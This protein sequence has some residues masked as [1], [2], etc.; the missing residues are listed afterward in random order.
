MREDVRN[1]KSIENTGSGSHGIMS[2][3]SIVC[4]ICSSGRVLCLVCTTCCF[5]RGVLMLGWLCAL[6]ASPYYNRVESCCEAFDRIITGERGVLNLPLSTP[7]IHI[8]SKLAG[9]KPGLSFLTHSDPSYSHPS[10]SS[11]MIRLCQLL[12]DEER[13]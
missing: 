13:P 10:C 3:N 1:A 9:S 8:S 5:V 7:D 11:S 12:L 2:G 6:A 4:S